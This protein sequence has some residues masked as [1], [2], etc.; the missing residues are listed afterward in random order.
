MP[1]WHRASTRLA[2]AL[3]NTAL[4]GVR[5]SGPS[6]A[7]NPSA[8]LARQDGSEQW[9]S[10]VAKSYLRRHGSQ[11]ESPCPLEYSACAA[12]ERGT[13]QS[14]VETQLGLRVRDRRRHGRP[15]APAR[16]CPRRRGMRSQLSEHRCEAEQ[17]GQS[18]PQKACCSV[19][20]HVLV[21]GGRLTGNEKPLRAPLGTEGLTWPG[22]PVRHGQASRHTP[23][24]G[25]R[26]H[27]NETLLPDYHPPRQVHFRIL[28]RFFLDNWR[29]QY[30]HTEAARLC[31]ICPARQPSH[32][33]LSSIS[34]STV[35]YAVCIFAPL[36]WEVPAGHPAMTAV[37]AKATGLEW[38]RISYAA[39]AVLIEHVKRDPQG[40]WSVDNAYGDPY[41]R[42]REEKNGLCS[43]A[44]QLTVVASEWPSHS[45][46]ATVRSGIATKR[47]R[48]EFD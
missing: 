45:Q 34:C 48:P 4:I 12:N 6:S 16:S 22:L 46:H 25:G 42:A 26:E 20:S 41:D 9:N 2:G 13:A 7:Q 33:G 1:R 39:G 3:E 5:S 37:C 30:L 44:G 21:F 29:V 10:T 35:R 8:S 31:R 24:Q 17:A 28:N 14:V 15:D 23:P 18:K 36:V 43:R 38:A 47:Y 19:T 11:G 32:C 27:T 40:V